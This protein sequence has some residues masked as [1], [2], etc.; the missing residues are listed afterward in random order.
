MRYQEWPDGVPPRDW[1]RL[2]GVDI[3][4]ASPWAWEWGA[5]DPVGNLIIYEELYEKTADVDRFVE[6][7]L[8]NMADK[9]HMPYN[10]MAKVIDY[11]NKVAAEDLRR[12]GIVMTNAA[13][14]GKDGSFARMHGYLH[15]NPKHHFPE[16]HPKAGKP[17]SPRLFIMARCKN[18]IREFPQQRWKDPGGGASLKDIPDKSIAN[19]AVDAVLYML[20]ELPKPADLKVDQGGEDKQ[21][22]SLAS[23]LYYAD[24]EREKQRQAADNGS[25]HRIYKIPFRP[26]VH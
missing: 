12:R 4:G 18:L 24:L 14:H 16:W 10:F 26:L 21:T 19:H 7:A 22:L 1:P 25:H 2:L 11:E 9:D 6:R 13:K 8:I 3:G 20:R 17:Y 5:L 23:R 15:P